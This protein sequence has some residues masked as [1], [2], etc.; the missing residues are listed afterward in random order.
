MTFRPQQ[1]DW[2]VHSSSLLNRLASIIEADPDTLLKSTDGRRVSKRVQKRERDRLVGLI[3]RAAE[4]SLVMLS[5]V[6]FLGFNNLDCFSP[7]L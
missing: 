5:E 4:N 7:V 6:S 2:L 3:K 1:I